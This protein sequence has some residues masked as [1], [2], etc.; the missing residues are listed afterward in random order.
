MS[1]LTPGQKQ[2][3]L[4]GTGVLLLIVSYFLVFRGNMQKASDLSAETKQLN[5]EID[6][7]TA[8]QVEVN[9]MR[10][11]AKTQQEVVNGFT[12]SFPSE[13]PEESVIYNIYRLM[14]KSGLKISSIA[15][16]DPQTFVIGG[17]YIPFDGRT[18]ENLN[19][20]VDPATEGTSEVEL[21]PQTRVSLN[22]MIGKTVGCTLSISGTQKQVF[23]AIDWVEQ[24][25]SPM[26][27]TNLNLSFD[28][29]TGLLSGSI[30]VFFHAMNGNGVT[31]EDPVDVDDFDTGVKS[32]WGIV[33]KD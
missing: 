18:Y 30:Q 2:L 11:D 13:L 25:D 7:L 12:V 10:N 9:E 28:S 24:N 33:K 16:T 23:K 15:Y 17:K 3:I 5:S 4:I 20:A 27:I 31:Y 14:V 21:N 8:L 26:S 32:L 6:R 29:S 1:S 22:Q 19:V